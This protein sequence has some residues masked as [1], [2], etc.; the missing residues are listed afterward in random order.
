MS[1]GL[2]PLVESRAYWDNQTVEVKLQATHDTGTDW[3]KNK[4]QWEFSGVVGVE[5]IIPIKNY[6]GAAQ[7]GS[8][9]IPMSRVQGT[10][11]LPLKLTLINELEC[12]ITCN[13]ADLLV[14]PSR[15]ALARYVGC[16]CVLTPNGNEAAIISQLNYDV[17]THLSPNTNLLV[18]NCPDS[19]AL[20][21]VRDGGKMLFI[22]ED[23][24]TPFW[25]RGRGGASDGNWIKSFSWM[26]PEVF[27]N[28]KI[29]NPLNLPLRRVM[30]TGSILGLACENPID[31]EDIL[32]GQIS[33]WVQR[34]AIHMVQFRYGR[35]I[36]IMTTYSLL[37]SL[38]FGNVD[39]VGVV[40]IND[41]VE[42]LGSDRCQPKLTLNF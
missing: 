16:V 40:M 13:Q 22:S 3:T 2:V 30:P 19:V 27:P 41:L 18:T 37:E 4:L 29:E 5:R 23:E 6:V 9:R 36:V 10:R 14:L 35:G 8:I 39:P 24:Y 26:R 1:D 25:E 15:A 33:G 38:R 28:L 34:P 17:E 20:Q 21:W 31:N 11:L 12:E 32:A 42:Y 7:L